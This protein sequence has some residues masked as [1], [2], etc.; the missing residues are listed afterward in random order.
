MTYKMILVAS[1]AVSVGIFRKDPYPLVYLKGEGPALSLRK[2][3]K[4][5]YLR[6]APLKQLA[7]VSWL[8]E[9]GRPQQAEGEVEERAVVRAAIDIDDTSEEK[10]NVD[11]TTSD[12]AEE[13]EPAEIA[14]NTEI[15]VNATEISFST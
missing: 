12:P 5:K 3:K 6:T 7:G 8:D 2:G 1:S 9:G 4:I 10:V 11:K 13:T 14:E 15:T